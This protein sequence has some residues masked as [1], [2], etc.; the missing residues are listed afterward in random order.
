VKEKEKLTY[1]QVKETFAPEEYDGVILGDEHIIIGV[2]SMMAVR[3]YVDDV[4]KPGMGVTA[5]INLVKSCLL[6][7]TP[8]EFDALVNKRPGILTKLKDKANNLADAGVEDLKK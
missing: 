8:E 3:R 5:N 4:N 7:H 1:E 2:P 6:T